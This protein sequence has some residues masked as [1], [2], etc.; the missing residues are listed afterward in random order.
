[1]PAYDFKNTRTGEVREV[2]LPS[3]KVHEGYTDGSDGK[4]RYDEADWYVVFI[5]LP[6][7]QASWHIPGS[8][9]AL[10][11]HLHANAGRRRDG[12][13]TEE[14][15]ARLQRLEPKPNDDSILG[16]LILVHRFLYYVAG[17]PVLSDYDY[18]MLERKAVALLPVTHPVHK[19]G[20]DNRLDYPAR[21]IEQAEKV[22]EKS[23]EC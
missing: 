17:T 20:S 10:F 16:D 15:Y 2:I 8:E 9:V 7:G 23:V 1:M 4:E 18:D 13:A 21:I 14:K 11:A 22:W 6:T 3:S 12:H 5:D 19:P